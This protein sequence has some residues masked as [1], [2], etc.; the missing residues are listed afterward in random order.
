MRGLSNA[1]VR[2]RLDSENPGRVLSTVLQRLQRWSGY[3]G[4]KQAAHSWQMRRQAKDVGVVWVKDS[5]LSGRSYRSQEL[6]GA[7][8]G[9]GC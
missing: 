2:A 7:G 3:G 5:R 4:Q 8:A 1:I 6:D 9:S